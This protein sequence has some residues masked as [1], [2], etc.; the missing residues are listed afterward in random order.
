MVVRRE[1]KFDDLL[2]GWEG[3]WRERNLKEMAMCKQGRR[4]STAASKTRHYL[5]A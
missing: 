1:R 3:A 4:C 2:Q 5:A